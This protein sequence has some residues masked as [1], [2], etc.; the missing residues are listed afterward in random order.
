M[1]LVQRFERRE[2]QPQDQQRLGCGYRDTQQMV[3][4]AEACEM[5]HLAQQPSHDRHRD[6]YDHE[7][8]QETACRRELFVQMQQCARF[9]TEAD[10][11]PCPQDDACER[12]ELQNEPLPPAVEY[13]PQHQESDDQVYYAHLACVV[14]FMPVA[15]LRRYYLCPVKGPVFFSEVL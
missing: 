11:E 13:G 8:R 14:S 15:C 6:Q 9:G 1:V 12:A 5:K 10:A 7:D 4:D 3:R 2:E